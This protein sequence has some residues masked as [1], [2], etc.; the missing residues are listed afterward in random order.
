M[1]MFDRVEIDKEITLPFKE[2]PDS[3]DLSEL[4]LQ[5][6]CL[7][8]LLSTY[9]IKKD[10]LYLLEGEKLI[11]KNFHGVLK[12]GAYHS[13]DL[14]DYA[15]DFKA[16]YTDGVLVNIELCK[17]QE[18]FHES[19]KEKYKCL[20]EREKEKRKCP[21]FILQSL[22]AKLINRFGLKVESNFLGT[23]RKGDD[24]Y[25]FHC[26]KITFVRRSDVRRSDLANLFSYGLMIENLDFGFRFRFSS[27]EKSFCLKFF[28][29]GFE[30]RRFSF[31]EIDYL[32]K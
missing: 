13:T 4:E 32:L 7:D 12:F 11:N 26:P 25:I 1:G 9:I 18:F 19:K 10:G 2:K 21:I 8:N 23:F 15:F 22:L 24:I 5:T 14:I 3:L 27:C 20:L 29:L 30:F 31:E 16:K 6:K 17:F 28:G